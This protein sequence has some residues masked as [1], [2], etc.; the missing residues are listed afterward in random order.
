MD[1]VFMFLWELLATILESL[2]PSQFKEWLFS[3]PKVLRY[4]LG[5]L[6]YIIGL[7]ITLLILLPFYLLC[8]KIVG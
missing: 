7:G 4:I 6:F 5:A 1:D 8:R 3:L 2:F